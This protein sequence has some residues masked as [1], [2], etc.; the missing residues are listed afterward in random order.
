M[1]WVDYAIL[2][3]VALSA[4]IGLFRGFTRE[5]IG[6]ATWILAF[7]VAYKLAEPVAGLL[8]DLISARSVRLAAA[9]GGV[10]IIVLI[11]G[12]VVNYSI[13][14]LVTQ[15]GFAGT[16]RALGSIFGVLRGA[17][18]L[19]VLVLLAGFTAVPKDQWWQ[20]SIFIPHLEEGA[21][22]VRDWLPTDLA[23]EIEFD[24]PLTPAPEPETS[25][26]F[27][28]PGQSGEAGESQQAIDSPTEK[29]EY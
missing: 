12:A 3:I 18:V 4:V 25:A 16:D 11:I 8:A 9:F 7:L 14:K 21:V 26:W 23:E 15:T 28:Q 1:I 13:S 27:G 20:E 5:A 2:G 24:R 29:Q 19:V 22:W 6:L 17:G 10:F